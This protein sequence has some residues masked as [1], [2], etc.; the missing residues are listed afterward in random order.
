MFEPDTLYSIDQQFLN[1]LKAENPARYIDLLAYRHEQHSFT[2][3]ELSELLIDCA[4]ILE[5]FLVEFFDI[6]KKMQ[7]SRQQTNVNNPIFYFKKWYCVAH[8]D[9]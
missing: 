1:Y 7:G 8:D 5:A 2:T 6:S 9:V 3:V 4:K